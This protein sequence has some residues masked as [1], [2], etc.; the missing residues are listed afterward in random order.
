MNKEIY[1]IPT[2]AISIPVVVELPISS[3]I[4]IKDSLIFKN[5]HYSLNNNEFNPIQ[6]SPPSVWKTRLNKRIGKNNN[7][8]NNNNNSIKT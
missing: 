8:N 3:S 7:N 1:E 5:V 2:P 4:N 6:N